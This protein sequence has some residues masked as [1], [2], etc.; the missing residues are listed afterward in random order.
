[1]TSQRPYRKLVVN[2]NFH[3]HINPAIEKQR[4]AIVKG[5]SMPTLQRKIL[6]TGKAPAELT[7]AFQDLAELAAQLMVERAEATKKLHAEAVKAKT[8][9]Y[10]TTAPVNEPDCDKY[11]TIGNALLQILGFCTDW[12]ECMYGMQERVNKKW[13]EILENYEPGENAW[14]DCAPSATTE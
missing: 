7:K 11:N 13:K 10:E 9:T 1:M 14:A 6:A 5:I 4:K 2:E 3:I 12:D 8:G